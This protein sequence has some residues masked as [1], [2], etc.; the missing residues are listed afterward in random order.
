MSIIIILGIIL[1]SN[2]RGFSQNF[3]TTDNL[4]MEKIAEIE[5]RNAYQSKRQS[6]FKWETEKEYP[7]IVR[8]FLDSDIAKRNYIFDEHDLSICSL[9]LNPESYILQE[10]NVVLSNAYYI[11][12]N[13][14][15]TTAMF[16]IGAVDNE[17]IYYAS[18]DYDCDQH[19]WCRWYSFIDGKVS[20]L[21]EIEDKTFEY[22]LVFFYDLPSFFA[23]NRGYYYIV[24][25]KNPNIYHNVDEKIFYKIS[26]K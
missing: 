23:D 17:Q 18:P 6:I 22:D 3:Q 20:I 26:L 7:E 25:Q 21:A 9:K 13:T 2:I 16:G 8:C 14:P 4:I 10:N 19:L 24:V 1:F 12:G 11:N 5:F 15:D